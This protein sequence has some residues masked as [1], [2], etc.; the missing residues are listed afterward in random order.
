VVLLDRADECARVLEM[1]AR[2][3][4]GVSGALVVRGEAGIGKTALL[5]YAISEALDLR[6]VSAAAQAGESG[7]PFAC[8]HRLLSGLMGYAQAIPQVQRDALLGALAMGPPTRPEDRF[9]VHVAVLSL[10]G[11][12][13]DVG[14]MLITVDDAQWLDQ[15][16]AEIFGFVVQRLGAEGV[17][18][19]LACRDDQVPPQFAKFPAV[20]LARLGPTAVGELLADRLGGQPSSGLAGRLAEASGGNPLIVV[21][22]AAQLTAAQVAG[23]VPVDE[24]V[25]AARTGP[26]Q[27]LLRRLDGVAPDTRRAAVLAAAA[28]EDELA[29]ALAAA[30]GWGIA[31]QAFEDLEERG[32]ISLERGTLRFFHPVMRAAVAGA[33]APREI[34]AAHRALAA[35]AEP[36][37]EEPRAWH[38]AAAALEPD[39]EVARALE[40]AAETAGARSG[41]A[42]AGAA[43]TRAAELS[44]SEVTRSRRRF[45]AAQ[46]ARLAGQNDVARRLLEQVTGDLDPSLLAAVASAR[47]R[48]EFREGRLAVAY[49]VLSDA[50]AEA[51]PGAAAAL[52]ADAAMVSFL[53]GDPVRAVELA[54][55]AGE[56]DTPPESNSNLLVKLIVGSAYM[57]L[58]QLT[59][60]L[61]LVREAARI[62]SLPPARRPDMEYVIFTALGLVWLG[63]HA[64]ARELIGPIV[65]DLRARSALG[66]LPFALYAAAYADARAGRLGAAVTAAAEAAG[67]AEATGDALWRY[68]AL[69]GLALAEA[70]VGDEASCRLH[71]EEAL[72]MLRR[73]DLDYPRDATDALGLLELGLGN[74]EGAIG[75]LE[76]ANQIRGSAPVLARPSAT[77]LVEAYVRAGR[78]VPQAM[79]EGLVQQSGDEE[80]PGNAAIA[81]RCRGLIAADEEYQDCFEAA[82]GLHRRGSS[83]FETGRTQFCFGERLRRGGRRVD[84]REHLRA[85]HLAFDQLGARLWAGR[86]GQELRAAGE[87]LQPA[88]G[89]PSVAALTPQ[90]RAVAAAVAR[91]HTNQE[92][93]TML[94]LSPK[95]IEMH[96]SRV[97]RKL[98][99][100]SRAEL[101]SRFATAGHDGVLG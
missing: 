26:A 4:H 31:E 10:I 36:G 52:L 50:S 28:G 25:L 44:G 12:V 38:L 16:T 91:G 80:F 13:A 97:Y 62:A 94:F 87:M 34:R 85:A 61:R 37:G 9:V 53:A 67:L 72:V 82:L 65:A 100:R 2:A 46:A 99:L 64:A 58:G 55:Q 68:L 17:V 92:A 73:F 74:A 75:Y 43:L 86:A 47:G 11:A 7:L 51:E 27:L 24:L 39:E 18:V 54:W 48:L 19:L 56:L 77:D 6:V 23:T 5:G 95:T 8:L 83:P 20:R 76:Q 93:A 63:D 81:W 71:A 84:A 42:A 79:A 3:R 35:R 57:H 60:G 15:A 101:A 14:P 1:L 66:V 59:E 69:G 22:V 41:Y 98:G 33:A 88:A 89:S 90:E 30:R 29:G 45:A 70:Q 49:S 40:S 21:E 96:L 78:P 32:V